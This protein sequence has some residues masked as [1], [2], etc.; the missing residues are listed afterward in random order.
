MI[1]SDGFTISITSSYWPDLFFLADQSIVEEL[2]FRGLLF[3]VLVKY[4]GEWKVTLAFAVLFMAAHL[5]N[6]NASVLGSF[7]TFL[8]SVL[9]AAMAFVTKSLFMPVAFHLGWNLTQGS[10]LSLPVSGNQYPGLLYHSYRPDSLF[11]GGYYGPEEGLW[12]TLYL[13]AATV[14]TIRYIKPSPENTSQWFAYTYDEPLEKKSLIHK[15]QDQK[16]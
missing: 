5:G 6:S 14:I 12:C 11:F 15:L 13:I 16:K 1:F 10:V 7:N 9:I 8:A 2:V 3:F 4:F